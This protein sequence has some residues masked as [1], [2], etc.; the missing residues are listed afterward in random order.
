MA[1]VGVILLLVGVLVGVLTGGGSDSG[2]RKEDDAGP[3]HGPAEPS[4]PAGSSEGDHTPESW[5]NLPEGMAEMNGLPVKFPRTD[6]GAVAAAVASNRAGWSMD[7]DEIRRGMETYGDP[8]A[9]KEGDSQ[10]TKAAAVAYLAQKARQMAGVPA[11]GPVPDGVSLSGVPIGVQWKTL[12]ADRVRVFVLT[13]VTSKA[14]EGEKT[15]TRLMAVP[16]EAIWTAGDWKLTKP[17]EEIDRSEVP[18]PA[19][20]GTKKFSR[21]GWKALQEASSR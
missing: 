20:L 1:L 18:D 5:V 11:K 16:S 21:E 12:S 15:R 4:E 14:G 6:T 8:S 9:E 19:D 2:A 13:R 17:Q 3:S 7:E 10:E